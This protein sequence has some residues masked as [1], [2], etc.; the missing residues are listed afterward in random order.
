MTG[1]QVGAPFNFK[2]VLVPG[3]R[4]AHQR[5][6]GFWFQ[7]G[8]ECTRCCSV[9]GSWQFEGCGQQRSPRHALASAREGGLGEPVADPAPPLLPPPLAHPSSSAGALKQLPLTRRRR[10]SP[11]AR[12]RCSGR[13]SPTARSSPEEIR[14]SRRSGTCPALRR[15]PPPPA[16]AASQRAG[17][18]RRGQYS[19]CRLA[20]RV[21]WVPR[22]RLAVPPLVPQLCASRLCHL[23]RLAAL[24]SCVPSCVCLTRRRVFASHATRRAVQA[25]HGLEAEVK[26]RLNATLRRLAEEA[27]AAR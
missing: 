13:K 21:C 17:V 16:P 24:P 14:P 23:P 25:H 19:S 7:R 5:T 26:S 18:T 1:V 3:D 6:L 9:W 4:W 22:P 10:C 20:R 2:F 15:G 12:A 27:R 8:A 11:A